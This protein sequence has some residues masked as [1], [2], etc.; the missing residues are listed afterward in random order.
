MLHCGAPNAAT[1]WQV[2]SD[3][4]PE[5][6]LTLN[7]LVASSI[8]TAGSVYFALGNFKVGSACFNA[9]CTIGFLITL[10]DRSRLVRSAV[11]IRP[12][13]LPK[14]GPSVLMPA[15]LRHRK[16]PLLPG[17]AMRRLLI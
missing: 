11:P 4:F 10:A 5:W 13:R 2:F 9:G 15:L 12:A 8:N 7:N 1:R 14:R 6:A 3:R 16:L 17:D